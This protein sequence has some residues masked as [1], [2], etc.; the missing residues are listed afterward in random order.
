MGLLNLF[1]LQISNNELQSLITLNE[2]PEITV[3]LYYVSFMYI[4]GETLTNLSYLYSKCL[5]K[6]VPL[7]NL[8]IFYAQLHNCREIYCL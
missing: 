5:P 6:N 8:S 3:L 2:W 4:Q 1:V 7:Y